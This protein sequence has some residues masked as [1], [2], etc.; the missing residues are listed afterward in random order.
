MLYFCCEGGGRNNYSS[1]L[2]PNEFAVTKG[3]T[4]R[5]DRHRNCPAWVLQQGGNPVGRDPISVVVRQKHFQLVEL[6]NLAGSNVF[7]P[8][9]GQGFV[10]HCE[11]PYL[12]INAFG[13]RTESRL[14]SVA[15]GPFD[16]Q[17]VSSAASKQLRNLPLAWA[18]RSRFLSSRNQAK[19]F[20]VTRSASV[21]ST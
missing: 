3:Q 2:S 17:V 5:C 21:T 1:N 11:G 20:C 8:Q 10:P 18:R 9:P 4:V 16:C 13:V 6:V 14:T 12:I 7:F 15:A 19:N